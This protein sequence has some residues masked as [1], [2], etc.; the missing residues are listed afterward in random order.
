MD[1]VT[2]LI[3]YVLY[4]V[5]L[6]CSCQAKEL[7]HMHMVFDM[8][9]QSSQ[10]ELMI[11]WLVILT[12]KINYIL[13]LSKYS[14]RYCL[15]LK[16][17]LE[18]LLAHIVPVRIY[19]IKHVAMSEGLWYWWQHSGNANSRSTPAELGIAREVIKSAPALLDSTLAVLGSTFTASTGTCL[20]KLFEI[21]TG[22]PVLRTSHNTKYR[23]ISYVEYCMW[24]SSKR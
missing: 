11:F 3:T 5:Q 1:I 6:A 20:R 15:H 4:R 16:C 22:S 14:K 19:A 10:H 21:Q 23:H 12:I 8:P 13:K 2:C 9:S 7:S 24:S 17:S 18:I